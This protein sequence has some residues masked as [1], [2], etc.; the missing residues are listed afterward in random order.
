M[1]ENPNGF[2]N[3]QPVNEVEEPKKSKKGLFLVLILLIIIAG[4]IIYFVT[5]KKE[6]PNN[7]QKNNQK[8][9]DNNN[10]EYN[11]HKVDFES[12]SPLASGIELS[13]YTTSDGLLY[14]IYNGTGVAVNVTFKTEFYDE[15]ESLIDT[16]DSN[17]YYISSKGIG[18]NLIYV[19]FEILNYCKIQYST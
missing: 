15:S 4:V 11:V 2:D 9:K 16:K 12:D 10:Q 18:Y 3:N 1:N 14:K 13:A 19:S 5:S 17:A 8:E 7:N 6:E